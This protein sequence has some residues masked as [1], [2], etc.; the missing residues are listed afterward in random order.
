[1]LYSGRLTIK[2]CIFAHNSL[3]IFIYTRLGT[4]AAIEECI[5]S[6]NQNENYLAYSDIGYD[7]T[8]YRYSKIIINNCYFEDT[9]TRNYANNRATVSFD[10]KNNESIKN[11]VMR[12][13][14]NALHPLVISEGVPVYNL[15]YR[16]MHVHH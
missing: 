14:E 6:E 15:R 12:K 7:G 8:A 2:Q 3:K 10:S 16:K 4:T 9:I 5:F 13:V 11:P 1:M